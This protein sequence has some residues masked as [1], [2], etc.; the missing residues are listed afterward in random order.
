LQA[1]E[2]LRA[3][4]RTILL[5]FVQPQLA[6]WRARAGMRLWRMRLGRPLLYY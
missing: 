2:A 3:I 1:L 6:G 4:T 5:D